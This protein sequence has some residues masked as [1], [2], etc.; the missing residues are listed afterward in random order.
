M[1]FLFF[2]SFRTMKLTNDLTAFKMGS[3]PMFLNK[4]TKNIF[5]RYLENYIHIETRCLKDKCE[6]TLNMYY[7]SKN[8][9]K[10]QIHFGG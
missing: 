8:H 1:F 2:F 9:Q 10:K 6:S 7:N 5:A 4:L 3:D